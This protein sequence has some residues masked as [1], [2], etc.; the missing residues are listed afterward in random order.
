MKPFAEGVTEGTER[1]IAEGASQGGSIEK[2]TYMAESAA[3]LRVAGT[4]GE[5]PIAP[6]YVTWS[7]LLTHAPIEEVLK[8][9]HG[10]RNDPAVIDTFARLWPMRASREKRRIIEAWQKKNAEEYLRAVASGLLRY[11]DPLP[12]NEKEAAHI[13]AEFERIC[14]FG[15]EGLE[16]E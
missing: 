14:G 5:E 1:L 10:H 16:G 11:G 3:S 6:L 13:A 9:L 15:E 4:V 2:Y 7:D 12:F 8:A